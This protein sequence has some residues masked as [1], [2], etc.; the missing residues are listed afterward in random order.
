MEGICK[1]WLVSRYAETDEVF[2]YQ[3][4]SK[5]ETELN[6]L[7]INSMYTLRNNLKLKLFSR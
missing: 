3:T 7:V 2:S 4:T 5:A 6:F 1:V